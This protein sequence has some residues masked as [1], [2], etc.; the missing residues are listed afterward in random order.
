MGPDVQTHPLPGLEVGQ[1]IVNM[2]ADLV[3]DIRDG[4]RQRVGAGLRQ[5]RRGR[6]SSRFDCCS[7]HA[8]RVL[9]AF[10]GE[11]FLKTAQCAH[12]VHNCQIASQVAAS[13]ADCVRQPIRVLQ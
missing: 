2:L 11:V 5:L 9:W 3:E 8:T 1:A 7:K 10:G 4:R 13:D 6:R 12:F